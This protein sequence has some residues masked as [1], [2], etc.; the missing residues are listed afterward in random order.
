MLYYLAPPSVFVLRA[1]EVCGA[2]V[3]LGRAMQWF[4]IFA[5]FLRREWLVI[6]L[7]PVTIAIIGAVTVMAGWGAAELGEIHAVLGMGTKLRVKV[8]E[9]NSSKLLIDSDSEPESSMIKS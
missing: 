5:F 3:M 2:Y 4:L 1:V 7:G 8:F 9:T 6:G